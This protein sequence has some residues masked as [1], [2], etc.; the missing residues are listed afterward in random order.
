[1]P[2]IQDI[3]LEDVL[4]DGE[5]LGLPPEEI[6]AGVKRWR[7]KTFDWASQNRAD[8]PEKL[9]EG[10]YQL[11]Q[12][13]AAALGQL[14]EKA[15]AR[16]LGSV[17]A[18]EQEA[19]NFAYE[20]EATGF[21]PEL[22]DQERWKPAIDVLR[23]TAAND[24]W[25]LP[26]QSQQWLPV[27]LDDG[28]ELGRFKQITRPDGKIDALLGYDS[29][30]GRKNAR[31]TIDPIGEEDVQQAIAAAEQERASWL[32]A[33]EEPQPS[34]GLLAGMGPGAGTAASGW[35]ERMAEAERLAQAATQRLAA[36]QGPGAKALLTTERVGEAI[37]SHPELSQ[38]VGKRNLGED[39][40]RGMAG[41]F[42]GA[43]VA[44]NDITGDEAERDEW[45]AN[46]AN[47]R[48][49]LPGSTQRRN[50]GGLSEF[51]GDVAE[52]A[53]GMVPQALASVAAPML[54]GAARAAV[55]PASMT[56]MGVSAYGAAVSDTLARADRME[57][58]AE[59][60][61]AVDPAMAD[62]L[63]ADAAQA[64]ENY[65]L[66]SAG[67][68]S[69]EIASEFILPEEKL[70][71]G[72]LKGKGFLG[73]AG[74]ALG[75]S[76]AEG[77][78]AELGGQLIDRAAYGDAV[79]L[80]G[81]LRGGALEA[82]AGAPLAL[83]GAMKQPA[84]GST[85][86]SYS[87]S[88]ADESTAFAY[89]HQ[90]KKGSSVDA[91]EELAD[92]GYQ[93]AQVREFI[94]RFYRKEAYDGIGGDDVVYIPAPSSSG[95]NIIPQLL[96]ERLAADHGGTVLDVLDNKSDREAK[97]TR[98]YLPKMEQPVAI[99]PA[100]QFDAETLKGKR[101]VIVD[102]LMTSGQTTEAMADVLRKQGVEVDRFA[103]L[104]AAS[105]GKA[106]D[107]SSLRKLAKLLSAQT[108]VPLKQ[109]MEDVE[110]VHGRSR[111]RLVQ[112]AI[113]EAKKSNA[114]ARQIQD[115]VSR[116]AQALREDARTGGG[117]IPPKGDFRPPGAGGPGQVR[118]LPPMEEGPRD[119]ASSGPVSGVGTP[120]G[121]SPANGGPGASSVTEWGKSSFGKR[122]KT[123]ERLRSSWRAQMSS[124]L[125]RK[126][127]EAEWQQRANEF[128]AAHGIEGAGALYFDEESGL[129][130]SDRMAL[131]SQLIL[132]I[133]AEIRR[134]ELAGD[135]S[136][137]DALEDLQ[138]ELSES[139]DSTA[140]RLGQ[141]IRVLGMWT[142]MSAEG[143]LR[144]F[145]RKVNAA[146]EE[147]LKTTL[148]TDPQQLHAAVE[149]TAAEELNKQVQDQGDVLN[150]P[151]PAAAQR[152][153]KTPP[154]QRAAKARSEAERLIAALKKQAPR[155][156]PQ[157]Q[158][159]RQAYARQVQ[160][161][162]SL[163]AFTSALAKLNVPAAQAAQLHQLA[164]IDTASRDRVSD[165]A[166]ATSEATR[167]GRQAEA[168]LQSLTRQT[169]QQPPRRN[170][171]RA[172]YDQQART[173]ADLPTFSARLQALGVDAATAAQLHNLADLEH[174]SRLRAAQQA[175]E[176][177]MDKRAQEQAD[178]L[179]RNLLDTVQAAK[180]P[181]PASLRTLIHEALKADTMPP[182]FAAQA[183]AL[184]AKP[185]LAAELARLVEANRQHNAAI[186]R[187][188]AIDRLVKQITP[189]LAGTKTRQRVPRFLQ[190]LFD[191][192]ALGALDRAEFLKAYAEAF[193]LP[194]M[195][196][197]MS[198]KI[199]DLIDA[200]RAAPE[201][202]LKQEATTQLM[203]ELARF[204]GIS[205][206]DTG[207]AFWY[208]NILSGLTTQGV[209][210]FGNASNL[211]LRTLSVGFTHN[212]VETWQFIR[213]LYEGARRG[214]LEAG[215]AFS[216]GNVPFKGDLKFSGG[217]VLELLHSDNPATWKSKALN[218]IA[219]GRF[220]FRAL[221]A[222]DALFFHTAREG[223]AWLAAA[224]FAREQAGTVRGTAFSTYLAEQLN[225][226]ET[227]FRQAQDQARAEFTAAGRPLNIR[228]IDRR[229]WEIL[230]D[231]RPSAL[232]EE[233]RRFGLWNTLNQ[234]P[235]GTMGAIAGL[236]NDAHRR[237]SMPSPWGPVRVLTPLV[238]FV[239]IVANMTSAAL[240]FT[241][242]GIGRGL[243]GR[244]LRNVGDRSANDF[245]PWEARQRLAS[246]MLGTLGS[247]LLFAWAYGLKDENDDEVPFMIYG[248]GPGSK[249]RRDQMPKGWKPYTLKIGRSYWSYAETPLSLILGV[250][251]NTLDYLRYNPT[252]RK[253]TAMGAAAYALATS[254]QALLKTGVLSSIND[255]FSLLE[256][257][258]S[259]GQL[260]IRTATGFIPA[261]GLL[262]DISELFHGN[263]VDDTTLAAAFFKDV[264]V[265]RS[266]AGKPA[267]N[268]FGE[269]V[270]LDNL[271]RLPII[272]RIV[273]GQ[274]D[275]PTAVWL[276]RNKLWLPGLDKTVKVDAYLTEGDKGVLDE[277]ERN[278]QRRTRLAEDVLTP[279]EHY[280]LVKTGGQRIKQAV[281]DLQE[282]LK[283]GWQPTP[284]KL[285]STLNARVVA[286][287]RKTMREIAG[288]E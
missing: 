153:R 164:A 23:T 95:K 282:Q 126:E 115:L 228:Q 41:F 281:Q 80:G 224:R 206:M 88:T 136:T 47:L 118:G 250:A 273:T 215:N 78:A 227:H 34:I 247:S 253:E 218:F 191:A 131:G 75:K 35:A 275:D 144:A 120:A 243:L 59:Q 70:L 229:A 254:P 284:E 167:P 30:E 192:H 184:G 65:R 31:L 159:L 203:S 73:R 272:K 123:D 265:A 91:K 113:E 36:L 22:M 141:A 127:S 155:A 99:I 219:L 37:R 221:S 280:R 60:I 198:R 287:R 122:L 163:E 124:R 55:M 49:L 72:A 26:K 103:V 132:S 100:E 257:T 142:R 220:V 267:L 133:D 252:G 160:N 130:P 54:G 173:P 251:G 82:A 236:I 125:Y 11:D 230:E 209:N 7:D 74:E 89:G 237:L 168:L 109:T 204:K 274:G 264:P 93:P 14:R 238:P 3:A 146:R 69:A 28:N 90:S 64:R 169:P 139:V 176:T 138:H 46:L 9:F 87:A 66:I 62:R 25:Q 207:T 170:E 24:A 202:F 50:V 108:R 51:V 29:D 270:Q 79:D 231:K 212:P 187:Q 271:Q 200:Q 255:V 20:L 208:A 17:L 111:D 259:A 112:S 277:R 249:A 147:S 134:A 12:H 81:I 61:Q 248:M 39:F 97:N 240:D 266:L 96:A 276:A 57:A 182:D 137:V 27:T 174:R 216:T 149:Q 33:K 239:N 241:P 150:A 242:V 107:P 92:N 143:V 152:A 119:P 101:V 263:K 246:G 135:Q 260:A 117:S 140:T 104:T 45:R 214:T 110:L 223:R 222:G 5:D 268:I 261:Q 21:D 256:G 156:L 162:Q 285:Q 6:A 148:G 48:Q 211:L 68:A 185:A 262:R 217:Q 177:A 16:A 128:I 288:L 38:R 181:Q 180:S 10:T 2:E 172:A 278:T 19:A 171:I 161:P 77:T 233:S 190:K 76:F 225:H 102:D 234:E 189:K 269:P 197:A 84:R 194:I 114:N 283:S 213:G 210:L 188:R 244:H 196:S 165:E 166:Q 116:R 178:R 175:K 105:E 4:A 154:K 42:T 226:T 86:V 157:P 286:A 129:S 235:E 85:L 53:G 106:V 40:Y 179:M 32:K 121:D 83:A 43:R 44:W 98:G 1:M 258:R 13:A 245:T 195:D 67:K 199:R 158:L 279:E 186:A 232:V 58:Q 193:E 201:G 145:T 18:D 205:A 183:Q 8:D 52:G 151:D 63:R 15:T 94:D 56:G 71:T